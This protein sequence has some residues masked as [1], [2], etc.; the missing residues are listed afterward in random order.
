M[1]QSTGVK[2]SIWAYFP[3]TWHMV[4]THF[5]SEMEYRASF[6]SKI[7]GIIVNDVG[8]LLIWVV[9]F[10][11]FPAVNG[12]SIEDSLTLFS[13]NM[14]TFSV[15]A[16]VGYGLIDL[17]RHVANGGLDYFLAL[18]K[19]VLWQVATSRSSTESIGDFLFGLVIFFFT[20]ADALIKLPLFLL[21]AVLG[22]MIIFNFIVVV[23][24]FALFFGNYQET[25]D[26]WFWTLFNFSLYPQ[27]FFAGW[28]KIVSFVV[29]PVFF[30]TALPVRMMQD[31]QWTDLALMAGF[32][33]VSML[34]AVWFFNRGLKRYESGNMINIRV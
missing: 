28:L 33:L 27:N 29:V 1:S 9:F 6:L 31:F 13:L 26:R 23:F 10:Q 5:Q 3:L 2:H 20:Q 32:W 11:R 18:P 16:V 30:V 15:F 12:W 19:N 14:F 34:F 21:V 4:K 25:G 22:G 7:F 17:A 24:S 8:W